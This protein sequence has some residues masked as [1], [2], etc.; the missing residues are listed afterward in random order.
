MKRRS[1][2]SIINLGL[3]VLALSI[4]LIIN[5]P[6]SASQTFEWAT[7]KYKHKTHGDAI[8]K[9]H[10]VCPG[11]ASTSKPALVVARV[12]ADGDTQWIHDL[13]DKYHECIYNVDAPFSKSSPNLQVPANRGHEA[14]TY[15]TY[16]IDNFDT[17][18]AASV[19]V[20]GSRF[21]WHNDDVNYDNLN[22]LRRL[23]TTSALNTPSI[24]YH[25]LKC[26][27]SA[28]TCTPDSQPQGSFETRLRG[29]IEPYNARVVSDGLLPKALQQLFGSSKLGRSEPVRA[30]CCA[31]FIVSKDRIKQHSKEEYVAL[32]Q[33]LLDGP[34]PPDDRIAGRIVSYVW[35]ILFL[36]HHVIS[37][38]SNGEHDL[39]RMNELACPRAGDCYCNLYGL[40]DEMCNRGKCQGR[41]QLPP[42]YKLP[43]DWAEQH[44]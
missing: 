4:I 44:S 42:N 31:Q 28:S 3:F 11:L 26:D 20:H 5:R 24:G 14:M 13:S 7:I 1:N 23:N 38:D 19:F 22:L 32:R 2:A 41:Y 15:L 39:R 9:R 8:P 16:I 33:W 34:S 35:H 10:G 21:S 37:T 36:P 29:V 27:W 17:L 30:Q 25:N 40:C 18:P 6:S 43:T 12:Q